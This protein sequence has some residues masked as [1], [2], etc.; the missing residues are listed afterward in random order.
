MTDHDQKQNDAILLYQT[1]DGKTRL[2]VQLEGETVWL[3]QKQMAELF[4]KD[5]RTISEHIRNVF[6][7]GE[8]SKSAVIRNFRT[9]AET[10]TFEKSGG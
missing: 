6:D 3:S 2:E 7:D 10:I 1:E 8:L 9:T 4:Q 5:V